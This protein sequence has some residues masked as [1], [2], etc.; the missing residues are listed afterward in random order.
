MKLVHR[1]A[2]Y[3]GGFTIGLIIVFF[4]LNQK[5]VS[6]AYFPDARVL[7]HIRTKPRIYS[8]TALQNIQTFKF[9]TTQ[10][11]TILKNGDVDF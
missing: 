9:D 1:F 2:Y 10:I 11:S 8:P 4:V 7:K 5:N 3:F 6:C